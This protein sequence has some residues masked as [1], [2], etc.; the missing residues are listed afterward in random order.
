[1]TNTNSQVLNEQGQPIEGVY[2]AG[3]VAFPGLFG[4]EYPGC[5]VAITGSIYFGRVAGQQA[6]AFAK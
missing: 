4:T 5:G 3:E 6:A 1:M 2:A